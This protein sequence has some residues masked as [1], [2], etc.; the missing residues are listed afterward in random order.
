MRLSDKVAIITGGGSGLGRATS[1]LFTKE[2]AKVAVVD[3]NEGILDGIKKRNE[4]KNVL[5]ELKKIEKDL[6]RTDGIRYGPRPIDLDILFYGKGL[7]ILSLVHS[8]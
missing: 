8:A 1:I 2:G 6:G 5:A 3:I 4:K 7:S